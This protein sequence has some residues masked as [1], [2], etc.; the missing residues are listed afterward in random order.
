MNT[1]KFQKINQYVCQCVRFSEQELAIFNQLLQHKQVRKKTFLL[2]ENEVCNFEA[3]VLQGCIRTYYIDD[4]GQEV[5]LTFAIEDWWVSDIASF[6][7]QQPSQMYIEALEDCELLTLNPQSKEQLLMEAPRFE[8]VFR[9]MVQ[10]HLSSYQKRLYSNI[11]QAA[12]QRYLSFLQKYP[13]LPLRVPQRMIA[14]YLGISP[15]FLSKIRSKM[16]RR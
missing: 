1:A 5:I 7:E 11:A 14:S 8:R 6:H 3:Y 2:Q 12:Q 10:R 4:K 15:E 13:D 16:A 9:L